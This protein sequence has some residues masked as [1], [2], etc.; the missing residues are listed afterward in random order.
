MFARI[1]VNKA[2]VIPQHA[3]AFARHKHGNADLRI[4]LRQASGKAAQIGIAVLELSQTEQALV[5]R[6]TESERGFPT[7]HLMKSC[8]EDWRSLPVLDD[9]SLTGSIHINRDV[10]TLHLVVLHIKPIGKVR[11]MFLLPILYSHGIAG[12]LSHV[13]GAAREGHLVCRQREGKQGCQAETE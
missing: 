10:A 3:I 8:R 13:Q 11:G 1:E 4:H 5:T 7:L 12:H 6:G 2:V 9:D